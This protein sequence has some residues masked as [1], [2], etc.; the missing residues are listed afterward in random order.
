MA[1]RRV[2]RDGR[3]PAPV[4][5]GGGPGVPRR[6]GP[7]GDARELLA[8][9]DGDVSRIAD[10][11]FEHASGELVE[12]LE[13]MLEVVGDRF[14]VLD[15]VELVPEWRGFGIGALLAAT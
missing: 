4:Q 8:A 14:L 10:V 11:I 7:T 12:D 13:E 9:E 5:R 15:R 1:G 2:H 6:G 3:E